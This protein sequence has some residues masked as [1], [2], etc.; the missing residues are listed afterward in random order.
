MPLPEDPA[1]WE[2]HEVFDAEFSHLGLASETIPGATRGRV[3]PFLE[4]VSLLPTESWALQPASCTPT[5]R[6]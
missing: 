1:S 6:T 5:A 2:R 3:I 4:N